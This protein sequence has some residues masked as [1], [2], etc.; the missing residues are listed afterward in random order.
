MASN[1]PGE[2]I[3]G[4]GAHIGACIHA[5]FLNCLT[6]LLDWEQYV[7]S[8]YKSMRKLEQGLMLCSNTHLTAEEGSEAM[9]FSVPMP[10]RGFLQASGGASAHSTAR[11][12]PTLTIKLTGRRSIIMCVC[13]WERVVT[14]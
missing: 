8:V 12:S 9:P 1:S 14:S 13:L 2:C 10:T 3:Q 11:T 5:N 6:C 7:V 4:A